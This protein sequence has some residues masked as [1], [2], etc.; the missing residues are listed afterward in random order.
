MTKSAA[1]A[2]FGL[3]LNL[4]DA[5]A[6]ATA[7]PS[8]AQ[9]AIGVGGLAAGTGIIAPAA[10]LLA[11]S[12]IAAAI[13]RR[14]A[15]YV[16]CFGNHAAA[17]APESIGP[18]IERVGAATGTGF[19]AICLADP[20]AGRTIYQGHLF[21]AGRLLGNMLREFSAAMVGR[22]GMVDH[23]TVTA[24][25]A[26]MI[27]KLSALKDQGHAAALID[28]VTIHECE[29]IADALSRHASIAGPAWL[30]RRPAIEA[31]IPAPPTGPL[32]ILSGALDR[33]TLF[34][35]GV[36][37]T[38]MPFLQLDFAATDVAGSALQWA[39]PKLGKPFIIAASA[40]PDRLFR[41]AAVAPVLAEIARRLVAIGITRLIIT[42]TDTAGEVLAALDVQHLTS[43][44]DFGPLRWLHEA[45]MAYLIKPGGIG[46]RDLFLAE[47][48]PQLSLN[49]A[50]G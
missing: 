8:G 46:R 2:S 14:A 15:Q 36:A 5:A 22:I 3:A 27:T 17:I 38:A 6:L 10:T 9:I 32:A 13:A 20:W 33:Q 39:Q 41:G 44:A 1:A 40:P 23:A 37:A 11:P 48:G 24:G 16:I 12:E 21:Q 25:S 29:E 26:A 35:L 4:A 28:A 30:S 49:S 42:G 19:T 50:A 18:V 43:G 7:W 34:Q 47:F 45:G 31:A